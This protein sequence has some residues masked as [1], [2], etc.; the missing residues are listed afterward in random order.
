MTTPA[1]DPL[2]AQCLR[3]DGP[4]VIRTDA[5]SAAQAEQLAAALAA[6]HV[7]TRVLDGAQLK[8][9]E[10][11]LRALAAAFDFPSYFGHN[12]DALIDVWSDLS[13]LPAR[14]YVCVLRH[15]DAFA[16]ADAAAHDTLLDLVQH[17]ADRWHS[18]DEQFVFKL[19]RAA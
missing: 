5:L 4:A 16:R 15:A 17:V 12:W 13:W 3:P 14:G 8:G 10:D 1:P 6:Q 7:Q 18:D 19:V 9:K 11:L 2:L